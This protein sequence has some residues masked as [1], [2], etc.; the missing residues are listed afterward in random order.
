MVDALTWPIYLV[1]FV[2][3]E[4]LLKVFG[5]GYDAGRTVLVVL[6][7]AMLFATAV[8]MV[9]MVLN[10]AGRTAWNMVNVAVAFT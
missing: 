3:G 4:H 5:E 10:M 2:F 7:C 8:G 1:L 9:D 6:S